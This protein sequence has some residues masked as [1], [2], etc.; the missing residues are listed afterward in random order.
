MPSP[1]APRLTIGLVG[2]GR[3]GVA[4][5]K[6]LQLSGH[7][8]VALHA[9][10]ESSKDRA[11]VAFPGVPNLPIHEVA[12]ECQ[13]LLL[14]VP[15]DALPTVVAG[16]AAA[17]GFRPGM[18]V[19]HTSGSQGLLP[20]LPA[21]DG[22]AVGLAL[23]PAMTFTGEP[24][25]VDR[26]VACPFAVTCA[27]P[28]RAVAEMLVLEMGGEPVWVN[29]ADRVLYHA[30]LSHAANHMTVLIE[31]AASLLSDISIAEPRRLLTPLVTAALENA[32]QS[33]GASLTGPVARGD[34]G[35]VVSHLNELPPSVL[36]A[37][38]ALAKAAVEI[39]VNQ[40]G[41]SREAASDL[42]AVLGE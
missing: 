37:Y 20:L 10:S 36:P 30:A 19:V 15:D 25:D 9:V 27:E 8:I 14:A 29:D 7:N 3:V 5:A 11:A 31:Q 13:L 42:R 6:A 2:V 35:T 22:G 21:I 32:L 40:R 16:L 38:R 28:Y 17:H 23:H 12:A 24:A 1:T 41:L 26:L 39:A 18:F 34:V 33:G 4:L